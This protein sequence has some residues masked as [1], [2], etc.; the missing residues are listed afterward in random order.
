MEVRTKDFNCAILAPMA[1]TEG[2]PDIWTTSAEEQ[3]EIL[4][5]SRTGMGIRTTLTIQYRDKTR[6]LTHEQPITLTETPLLL[7]FLLGR[8]SPLVRI[9]IGNPVQFVTELR[10]LE[11]LPEPAGTRFRFKFKD[12]KTSAAFNLC[13]SSWALPEKLAGVRENLLAV[14]SITFP[15]CVKVTVVNSIKQ[16][17]VTRQTAG[18]ALT[19]LLRESSDTVSIL[20]EGYLPIVVLRGAA[21]RTATAAPK[22]DC[23]KRPVASRRRQARAFSLGVGSRYSAFS[24]K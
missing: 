21:A 23:G 24:L 1:A 8:Q 6:L 2:A 3:A 14:E 15:E 4:I 7:R 9:G 16:I 19:T 10:Y 13:R 18:D 12:E 20:A 11:T 5:G 17:S 22:Q